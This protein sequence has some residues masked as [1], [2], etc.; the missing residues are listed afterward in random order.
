MTHIPLDCYTV[1]MDK[2]EARRLGAWVS[3]FG[4]LLFS[5]TAIA[6][7]YVAFFIPPERATR[8][9]LSLSHFLRR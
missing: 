3:L 4:G 8:F 9:L 6:S 5:A 7:I 2:K 1:P